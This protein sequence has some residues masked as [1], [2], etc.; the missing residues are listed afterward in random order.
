MKQCGGGFTLIELLATTA[1]AGMLLTA[2][3]QVITI[4]GRTRSTMQQQPVAADAWRA[5]FLSVM[6]AD[7][8]SA[9]FAAWDGQLLRLEGFGG[10]D[11]ATG[12]PIH[13]PAIVTYRRVQD[14]LIREQR[15]VL[16]LGQQRPDRRLVALGIK[17]LAHG[18]TPPNGSAEVRDA[19]TALAGAWVVTFTDG[20]RVE[21]PVPDGLGLERREIR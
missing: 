10:R 13:E 5:Q 6:R 15:D 18:V 1:L 19:Q 8:R 20:S 3:L 7:L 4:T 21:V 14:T 16:D 2:L 11:R 9:S 17:S 12:E